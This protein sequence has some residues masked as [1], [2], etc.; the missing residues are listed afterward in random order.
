MCILFN[1]FPS[2]LSELEHVCIMYTLKSNTTLVTYFSL[3]SLS[4]KRKYLCDSKFWIFSQVFPCSNYWAIEYSPVTTIWHF[5]PRS[6]CK[7]QGNSINYRAIL[8]FP[9]FATGHF[10]LQGNSTVQCTH[11]ALH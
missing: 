5:L 6:P 1:F 9:V 4:E 11:C 7:L 8:F 10:W 2:R 3:S